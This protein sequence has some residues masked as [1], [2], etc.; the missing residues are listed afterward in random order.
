M[1]TIAEQERIQKAFQSW[2]QER[3]MRVE[4]FARHCCSLLHADAMTVSQVQALVQ[5]CADT[6]RANGKNIEQ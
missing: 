1:T 6:L 3:L 5:T 2:E 4:N